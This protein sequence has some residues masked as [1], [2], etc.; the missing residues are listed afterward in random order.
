ME[1]VKNVVNEYRSSLDE[2]VTNLSSK[3]E[4]A[5]AFKG[6]SIAEAIKGYLESI[7][8]EIQKVNTYLDGFDQVNNNTTVTVQEEVTPVVNETVVP[9]VE[10]SQ[11]ESA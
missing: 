3:I 9:V 5:N 8:G 6:S 1:N 10:T 11:E 4:Y 2:P 7:V